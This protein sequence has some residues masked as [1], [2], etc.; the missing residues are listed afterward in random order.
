M[1]RFFAP[2][3]PRVALALGLMALTGQTMA[4]GE[5]AAAD[6]QY[7]KDRRACVAM[8]GGVA[9][10]EACLREA[11]AVRQAARQ[12]G[13]PNQ[14]SPAELQRNALARCE[15]HQDPESRAACLRMAGG[16][17]ASQGSVEE[18]G[19]FRETVIESPAPQ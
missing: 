8:V 15:V 18:G 2:I 4:A 7:E 9:S 11:R 17:G 12:G 10:R 1:T 3:G 6:A 19:I 5:Q 14:V 13:V 16:E